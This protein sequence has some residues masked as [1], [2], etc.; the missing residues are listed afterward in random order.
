M[1]GE[2]YHVDLMLYRMQIIQVLGTRELMV[3]I[4]ITYILDTSEGS[5][6][7]LLSGSIVLLID[8]ILG[9]ISL[10]IGFEANSSHILGCTRNLALFALVCRP[11]AHPLRHHRVVCGYYGWF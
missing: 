4:G 5:L 6:P 9:I 2:G 1:R 3:V 11:R 8:H 10:V 7:G